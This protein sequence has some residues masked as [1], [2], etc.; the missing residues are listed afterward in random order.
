MGIDGKK[1]AKFQMLKGVT[2]SD[3]CLGDHATTRIKK[4]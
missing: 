4:V 2:K 3:W 1:D